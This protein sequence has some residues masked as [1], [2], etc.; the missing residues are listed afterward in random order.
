MTDTMCYCTV[1]GELIK[2]VENK[3]P[4]CF[5]KHEDYWNLENKLFVALEEN[6]ALKLQIKLL[7]EK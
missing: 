5:V 1:A 6:A 3:I 4:M 2:L 7:D